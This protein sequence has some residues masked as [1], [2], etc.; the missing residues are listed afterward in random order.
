VLPAGITIG[1]DAFPSTTRVQRN[2]LH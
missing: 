1:E 2:N